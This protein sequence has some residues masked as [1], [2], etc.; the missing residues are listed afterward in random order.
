MSGEQ[1]NHD[2]DDFLDD[3]VLDDEV[4]GTPP[5]PPESEAPNP[6]ST[7]PGSQDPETT[8]HEIGDL[9]VPQLDLPDPEDAGGDGVSAEDAA[10]GEFTAA[11]VDD[12]FADEPGPSTPAPADG[13]AGPDEDD[14]LF[15]D[16]TQGI[17]ASEDFEPKQQF[18]EANENVWDG[19]RLVLDEEPAVVDDGSGIPIDDEAGTPVEL[20]VGPAA[21][22]DGGDSSFSDELDS[23]LQEDEEDEFVLDSDKEL[24]IVGGDTVIA[25]A[26]VDESSIADAAIEEVSTDG[27]EAFVIDESDGEA[28]WQEIDLGAAASADA[29]PAGEAGEVADEEAATEYIG[30]LSEAAS[31][32][33]DEL[34]EGW[35]PLPGTKM[36][37]LAEVE[38]VAPVDDDEASYAPAPAQPALAAVGAPEDHDDLY[39]EVED[40]PEVVGGYRD[41]HRMLGVLSAVAALLVVGIGALIAV[42]RPEW[43]GLRFEP[44]RVEIVQIARPDV[45]I[46]ISPPPMP[47]VGTSGPEVTNP[48]GGG[49]EPGGGTVEPPPVE[50]GPT[51]TPGTGENPPGGGVEPTPV[52]DPETPEVPVEV[53]GAGTAVVPVPSPGSADPAWPVAVA[54]GLPA[55]NSDAA[56]APELL[57]VG[58]DLLVGRRS[59]L[60]IREAADGVMPGSR[61]FAQLDNGNYFIGS[62]KAVDTE[63]ITLRVATGEVSLQRD[64]IVRLTGLGSSDYD[65]LQKATSGF[66]RLTNNNRLVGG[67]LESIADDHVILQTRSNR[68]MLP[69]SVVGEIIRTEGSTEVRIGTT[70]EEDDW[71]R[72][73]S[74]RQLRSSDPRSTVPAADPK[75]NGR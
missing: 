68:V 70:S 46:D 59:E 3:F 10:D 65:E 25:G 31:G 42:Y 4:A 30:G 72:Q 37:E 26:P 43:F 19:E 6:G 7:E 1:Q 49:V 15:E 36:D 40:D 23:L 2:N 9:E 73:I 33:V 18:D 38:G 45:R 55:P 64:S 56:A 58:D 48:A 47:T 63:F 39:G 12:L 21:V 20:G 8:E 50:V 17:V 75:P 52:E 27:G 14:L 35:E 22:T 66:V 51:T 29:L 28:G 32:D 71:L 44:A 5:A 16:H 74:E 57:R 60:P 13:Q 61:A 67:I 41:N 53:G 54:Q 11:D 34:E 62:V 24:E 69:K